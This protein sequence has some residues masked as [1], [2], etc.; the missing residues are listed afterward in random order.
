MGVSQ[1]CC[2]TE[3]RDLAVPTCGIQPGWDSSA[4]RQSCSLPCEA[5]DSALF[6]HMTVCRWGVGYNACAPPAA[7][8]HACRSWSSV[9]DVRVLSVGKIGVQ[10]AAQKAA[11]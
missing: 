3:G 6:E 2:C 7:S 11:Q 1:D 8:R 9:C 5:L 4:C 10:T